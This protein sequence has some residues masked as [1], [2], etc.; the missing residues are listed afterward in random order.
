MGNCFNKSII[1]NNE[2]ID[3][4]LIISD[5]IKRQDTPRP[6]ELYNDIYLQLLKKK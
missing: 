2:I 5:L 6:Q 3:K 1:K 4:K